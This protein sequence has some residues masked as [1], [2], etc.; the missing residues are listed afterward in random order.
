MDGKGKR[1]KRTRK[2]NRQNRNKEGTGYRRG[3]KKREVEGEEGKER[4]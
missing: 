4:N 3:Y 2:G 1:G